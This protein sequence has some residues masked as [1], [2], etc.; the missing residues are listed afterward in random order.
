MST[1]LVVGV[2]CSTTGCKAIAWD[3]EGRAAA[4]GR[5][6]LALLQP[7]PG[8]YEQDAEDWWTATASALREVVAAAGASGIEALCVTHQRES[9]VPVDDRGIPLRNAILWLDER[10]RLQVQA[11]ERRLGAGLIHRTTGRPP[12][13]IPALPKILW[14]RENEPDVLKKAARL[15]DCHA[16]VVHRLCGVWRTS[17]ASADPLGLVDMERGRWWD[18]LLPEVGITAAQLPEIVA[19]GALIGRLGADAARATGLPAGLPVFAGGGDG[20]CA[21]LGAGATSP[22]RPYLNMGTAVVAGAW[23]QRYLTDRA[24]R[25]LCAPVAG[26]YYLETCLKGGV[27]TVGWFVDKWGRDLGPSPEQALEAEAAAVPLGAEGLLLVPYWHN[28]LNPYWDPA[29][30]GI[31]IGWTGTHGRG[32]FYRAVLEGIGYEQRLAGDGVMAAMGRRFEEYVILGGGSRSDLWCRIMADATGIPMARAAEAEA[33]CLGAG[34]LAAAGAGWYP[35][36]L[37]AAAAMTRTRE[38]F[39]PD[40]E[41]AAAYDLVYREVYLPLFPAVR[42]L[43]DRLTEITDARRELRPR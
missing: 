11:L 25:T 9:F 29:A 18:A 12:S 40:A 38:R 16:F 14:L 30:S 43:V 33:T 37:A 7:H 31:T 13:M 19:A 10:A 27:Y 1:G 24:F 36:A 28:V 6:Q 32:H 20:Q 15:L 4:V 41:R 21:G 2:D 22:T 8:W 39:E 35:D 26:A 42:P 34:I 5:A 23:S 3:R 17:L